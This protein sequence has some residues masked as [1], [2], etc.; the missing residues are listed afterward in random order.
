MSLRSYLKEV[1]RGWWDVI[2]QIDE[3]ANAM[4]GG[5]S[6]ET[7][8]GRT[9]RNALKGKRSSLILEWCIN[10][11]FFWQKDEFGRRNHCRRVYAKWLARQKT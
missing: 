1:A 4:G 8:S 11:I 5:S 3:A 2:V 10:L 9:G 6:R 7:I